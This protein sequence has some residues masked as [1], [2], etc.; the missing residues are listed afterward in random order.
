MLGQ[1]ITHSIFWCMCKWSRWW[2][3]PFHFNNGFQHVSTFVVLVVAISW[4][5]NSRCTE[6]VKV[7]ELIGYL[8]SFEILSLKLWC[9][10]H[11][12]KRHYTT[13]KCLCLNHNSTEYIYQTCRQTDETSPF[14][15]FGRPSSSPRISAPSV[16]YLLRTHFRDFFE[17]QYVSTRDYKVA[18][19]RHWEGR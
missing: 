4:N 8:R 19:A 5:K 1:Y 3:I 6:V 2:K 17:T 13:C 16:G 14:S 11:N 10:L 9:W 7:G 12:S 15:F 18:A